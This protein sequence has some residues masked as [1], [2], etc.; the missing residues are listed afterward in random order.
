MEE[1][2]EL[3][4]VERMHT[5]HFAEWA[6]RASHP[7]AKMIFR[8]A[9][10]KEANHVEWVKALI[11]IAKSRK[12]R[13]DF[14]VK[15]SDLEYWVEDEGGEGESYMK[16]AE[17]A[18]EPWVRAVLQQIGDDETTNSELL[19]TLLTETML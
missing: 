6:K 13:K 18:T 8:L 2:E 11:E 14:G 19:K 7:L 12:N 4:Y 10:D 5:A 15:K 16:T 17:K 9:A 3:L 1:L